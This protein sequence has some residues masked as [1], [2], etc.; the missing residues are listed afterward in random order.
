MDTYS[1]LYLKSKGNNLKNYMIY[2]TNIKYKQ[3]F[4]YLYFISLVKLL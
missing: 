1:K 2:K 4:S 3:L